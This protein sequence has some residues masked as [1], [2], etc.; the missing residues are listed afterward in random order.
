[1]ASQAFANYSNTV[2]NLRSTLQGAAQQEGQEKENDRKA[3]AAEMLS[4]AS[5]FQKEKALEAAPAA[6][7]SIPGVKSI[8]KTV[9]GKD[10]TPLATKAAKAKDALKAAQEGT[11]VEGC[12][13]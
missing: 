10:L 9:F 2:S 13:I 3:F 6:L 11:D 12:S 7:T 1:M 5:Q 8:A 4:Q